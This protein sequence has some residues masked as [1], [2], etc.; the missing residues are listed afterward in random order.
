MALPQWR[1]ALPPNSTL[2][3]PYLDGDNRGHP[4]PPAGL[5]FHP[6]FLS[7]GTATLQAI[8]ALQVPGQKALWLLLGNFGRPSFVSKAV[9]LSPAWPDGVRLPCA[10]PTLYAFACPPRV[11][12]SRTQWVGVA[13]RVRIAGSAGPARTRD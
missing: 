5:F 8:H 7:T 10:C 1:K 11:A 3:G 2:S 6:P 4:T 9:P 12:T 13:F